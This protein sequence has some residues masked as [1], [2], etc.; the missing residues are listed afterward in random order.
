MKIIIFENE[1]MSI[2]GAFEAA[3]LL[4][5]DNNL[6]FVVH[7]STQ[8]FDFSTISEFLVIFVDISLAKKSDLDGYSLIKKITEINKNLLLRV[9]ILTGNNKVNEELKI[10]KIDLDN[11]KILIKPTNYKELIK[12]I[13][14]ITNKP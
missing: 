8:N 1:F 7:P 5:F 13:K 12:V 4:G 14:F 6:E 2:E 10:R 3:S 9:V 11:S